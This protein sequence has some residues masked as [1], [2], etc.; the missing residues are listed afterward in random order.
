MGGA[1]RSAKLRNQV[2]GVPNRTTAATCGA[3]AGGI[4]PVIPA[5]RANSAGRVSGGGEPATVAPCE[6]PPSTILVFGQLAAIVSI[7]LLASAIPSA[8]CPKS[9]DAG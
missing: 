2:S 6:Y 8:A 9:N 5:G 4:V 7:L 1:L 3:I